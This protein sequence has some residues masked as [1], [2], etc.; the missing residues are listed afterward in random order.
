MDCGDQ[1]RRRRGHQPAALRRRGRPP[2]RCARCTTW[3]APTTSDRGCSSVSFTHPHDPY[4]TRGRVLGPATTAATSRCPRLGADD[5]P[6]D[7]HTA[8][9]RKVSA[10]DEVEITDAATCAT[11]GART[12]ATSPTSTSGPARL[13]RHARRARRGRRHRR[14]LLADH[15][16]MLGER[17][18]W[19][20]MNFF[21]GSG[22]I[23]LIVHGPRLRTGRVADAGVAARRAADAARTGRCRCGPRRVAAGPPCTILC[24]GRRVETDDRTVYGEYLGEGAIAPILMIRRGA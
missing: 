1:G 11:R 23:P 10:M 4:V 21:E 18:L 14:G 3:P 2:G 15:G 12:T 22:R 24:R 9:L 7:P 20:K 17:G 19:Y 5:V 8:R 13:T 6:L 16:D